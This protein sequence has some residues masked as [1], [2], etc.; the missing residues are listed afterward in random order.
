MNN[1]VQ[2]GILILLQQYNAYMNNIMYDLN[3]ILMKEKCYTSPFVLF[4]K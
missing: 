1:T 2:K 4:C 3:F